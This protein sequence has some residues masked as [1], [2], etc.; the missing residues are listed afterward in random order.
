M[1]KKKLFFRKKR[2]NV[3]LYEKYVVTLHEFSQGV[4]LCGCYKWGECVENERVRS[5]LACPRVNVMEWGD[6]LVCREHRIEVCL[7]VDVIGMG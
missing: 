7:S 1:H 3:W 4:C 6:L 5:V 2:R